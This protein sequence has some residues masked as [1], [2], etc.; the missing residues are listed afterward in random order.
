MFALDNSVAHIETSESDVLDLFKSPSLP[1][2]LAGARPQPRAAYVCAVKKNTVVRVYVALAADYGPIFVYTKPGSK[3]SEKTYRE[4]LEEAL[5]LTRSIG[6]SPERVDLD[7]SPAVRAVVVRNFKIFTFPGSPKEAAKAPA[8]ANHK[9]PVAE[10]SPTK[11]SHVA[12]VAPRTL[13]AFAASVASVATAA[14]ASVTSSETVANGRNDQDAIGDLLGKFGNEMAELR[15]ERDALSAKVQK[16]LTAQSEIAAEL[17]AAKTEKAELA[18]E[19]EKLAETVAEFEKISSELTAA[20]KDVARLAEER[21]EAKRRHQD[22]ITENAALIET[23]AAVKEQFTRSQEEIAGAREEASRAKNEAA[24][25]KENA[26]RAQGEAATA[27]EEAAKAQEELRKAQDDAAKA[28]RETAKLAK[29]SETTARC[30]EEL[31]QEKS[32]AGSEIEELLAKVASLDAE[33]DAALLQVE[34][35]QHQME[36]KIAE[37]DA[38]RAELKE[39][40]AGSLPPRP[41]S[42]PVTPEISPVSPQAPL[43]VAETAD[44]ALASQITLELKPDKA[45]PASFPEF[46]SDSFVQGDRGSFHIETSTC[47]EF[48]NDAADAPETAVSWTLEGGAKPVQAEPENSPDGGFFGSFTDDSDAGMSFVLRKDLSAIEYSSPDD[49]L[50]LQKSYNVANISPD[51]KAQESCEGYVCCLRTE[52]KVRVFAVIYGMK[53]GKI[54]VY[55]PEQEPSDDR[56]VAAAVASAACF[57]EQVGLMVESIPVNSAKERIDIVT[58]YPIFRAVQ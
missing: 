16:L 56:G 7:F 29:E 42:S 51:G 39:L 10:G 48:E 38:T 6:F 20:R 45:A 52:K 33:R 4:T 14:S 34:Y 31:A 28:E 24:A 53:S 27:R 26:E 47:T 25:A 36:T 13:A 43:A 11:A 19:R 8:F 30:A 1:I 44:D 35:L 50:Q 40:K 57:H 3:D 55:V 49:I 18:S 46:D 32:R 2:K 15:A 41:E 23:A 21:D 54:G 5:S 12:P 17:K 58:K 22:L 37:L 9:T